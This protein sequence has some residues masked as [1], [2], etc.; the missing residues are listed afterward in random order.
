VL[1]LLFGDFAGGAI[2]LFLAERLIQADYTREAEAGADTFAYSVLIEAGVAPG[3]IG[4]LFEG[5]QAASVDEDES[6]LRHFMSHPEMGDRMAA[7]RAATPEG[8][9]G[10]PILSAEEWVALQEICGSP[11]RKWITP[12]LGEDDAL[13]PPIE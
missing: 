3:A 5:L 1:G 7:S 10:T 4:D 9:V 6:I 13:L 8:F 11:P 2:V 12:D